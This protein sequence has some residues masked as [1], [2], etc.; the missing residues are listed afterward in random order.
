MSD[1]SNVIDFK[2]HLQAKAKKTTP[3]DTKI[4]QS[5]VV[6]ISE[7][8]A[9]ILKEERREV[10]RTILTEFVGAFVV[11]P[12]A[13]LVKV[14]LYDIS[15]NGISF[16]MDLKS[17]QFKMGEEVAMRVYLNQQTYFPFIAKIQNVRREDDEAVYRHGAHFLKDTINDKALH[18]FVKFIENVSAALEK[19][20]GDIMVSKI[21]M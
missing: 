6:D 9:E 7:R 3:V 8:R 13:G 19:D 11:I 4:K 12:T 17:G 10:K 14:A 21:G 5:P 15:E 1:K 20:T 16:D 2:R 18:H